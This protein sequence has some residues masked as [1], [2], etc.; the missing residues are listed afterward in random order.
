MLQEKF[1]TRIFGGVGGEATASIDSDEMFLG[2][3][4]GRW[5]SQIARWQESKSDAN[6]M[7]MPLPLSLNIYVL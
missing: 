3:H 7:A 6:Q 1:V 2:V 5:L 4:R